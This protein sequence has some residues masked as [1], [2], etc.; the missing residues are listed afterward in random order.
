MFIMQMAFVVK[1]LPVK[2]IK[3]KGFY[4]EILPNI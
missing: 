4:W 3:P 1:Y 2:G